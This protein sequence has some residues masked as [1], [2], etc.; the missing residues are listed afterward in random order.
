MDTRTTRSDMHLADRLF[1]RL[2]RSPETLPISYCIDGKTYHGM[3][4]G[5]K[6]TT[7]F[8][9][10]RMVEMVYTACVSGVQIRT[11]TLLYRDFPA[12]EWTIYL[13]YDGEGDSPLVSALNAA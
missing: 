6:T 8:V 12:A 13:T 9:D 11:E 10:S 5:T 3:P 7:R 2:L 1:A 4:A